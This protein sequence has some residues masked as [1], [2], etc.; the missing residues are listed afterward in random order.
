MKIQQLLETTGN[1]KYKVILVRH[2]DDGNEQWDSNHSYTFDA[3]DWRQAIE[4][5]KKRLP[6][7]ERKN[8]EFKKMYDVTN[9]RQLRLD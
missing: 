4:I 1:K 8:M 3:V 7:F 9:G 2:N 6:S 5:V